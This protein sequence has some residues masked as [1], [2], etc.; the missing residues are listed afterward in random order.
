MIIITYGNRAYEAYAYNLYRSL[1]LTRKDFIE[2]YTFVYYGI[3]YRPNLEGTNVV[4]IAFPFPEN[5]DRLEFM[6]P[7]ILLDVLT[8]FKNETICFIDADVIVGKRLNFKKLLENKTFEYPLGGHQYCEI[9]YIYTAYP[10]GTTTYFTTNALCEYLGV[11]VKV[12]MDGNPRIEGNSCRYIQNC[13]ILFNDKHYEFILEWNSIC[14]NK[15]LRSK[16][17]HYFPY[18]DETVFNTLLWK[19]N[20]TETLGFIHTNCHTFDAYVRGEQSTNL[21]NKLL[22]EGHTPSLVVNNDTLMYYHG[23]KN[24]KETTKILNY[25]Y[26]NLSS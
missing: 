20:V 12:Y 6:K 7:K 22:T 2:N 13:F 3:G 11:N 21:N 19:Y 23:Y 1:T 25:L 4:N 24:T 9:P 16:Q 10:D 15:F 5:P 26:E 14:E 18:P 8:K 17:V